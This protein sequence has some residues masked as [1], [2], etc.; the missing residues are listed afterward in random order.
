MSDDADL[1][2]ILCNEIRECLDHLDYLT[3]K[4]NM[5]YDHTE[6]RATAED[7]KKSAERL[8]VEAEVRESEAM[9]QRKVDRD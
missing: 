2:G 6:I 7:L 5:P 8:L 1:L 3:G 9:R 4:D